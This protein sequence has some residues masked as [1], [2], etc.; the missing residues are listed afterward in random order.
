[1]NCPRCPCNICQ[2]TNNPHINSNN[3]PNYINQQFNSIMHT[4]SNMTDLD[5]AHGLDSESES[6]LQQSPHIIITDEYL[7]NFLLK[8][9]NLNKT[10]LI[11]MIK[12][13][14]EK[15]LKTQIMKDFYNNND[16]NN[17]LLKPFIEQYKLFKIW[18]K[19]GFIICKEDFEAFV[20]SNIK[21]NF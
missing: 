18:N 21:I 1:M 12:N 15:E 7:L 13:T 20:E 6:D 14:K 10:K 3:I 8:K 17:L 9:Y 2:S 11:A 19:S 16:N 5:Y 4:D